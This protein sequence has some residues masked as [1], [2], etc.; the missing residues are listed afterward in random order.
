MS[1][2]GSDPARLIAYRGGEAH[3]E[4]VALSRIAAEVGTPC[5]VYSR[6]ALD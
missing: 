1:T 3:V 5:F 6:T 4:G 2:V